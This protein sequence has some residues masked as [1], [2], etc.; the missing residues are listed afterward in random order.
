MYEADDDVMV[1]VPPTPTRLDEDDDVGSFPRTKEEE[2]NDSLSLQIT[3]YL[4]LSS[5]ECLTTLHDRKSFGRTDRR[6]PFFLTESVW[7]LSTIPSQRT[8]ET[9]R[10][11]CHGHGGGN[12]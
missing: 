12:N 4:Y 5:V 1:V 11:H 7:P 10:S 3:T 2:I 6:N 9:Q 8:G